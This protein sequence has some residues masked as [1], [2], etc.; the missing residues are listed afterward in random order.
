MKSK[1]EEIGHPEQQLAGAKREL[2]EANCVHSES[3]SAAE[4]DILSLR[5]E[6]SNMKDER[7]ELLGEVCKLR[8]CVESDCEKIEH[9]EHRVLELQGALEAADPVHLEASRAAE[10]ARSLDLESHLAARTRERDELRAALRGEAPADVAEVLDA[11]RGEG[12]SMRARLARLLAVS[13]ELAKIRALVGATDSE[14]AL[15][16]IMPAWSVRRLQM[17]VY[18]AYVVIV[19]A[20]CAWFA[21]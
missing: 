21:H 2:E 3:S 13:A 1:S 20:I 5:T 10:S 14:S 7:D 16:K 12:E 18:F 4:S 17:Q 9:P 11:L 6:L 15:P 19:T 8:A